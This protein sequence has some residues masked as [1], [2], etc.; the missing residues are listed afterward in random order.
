[1]SEIQ[2]INQKKIKRDSLEANSIIVLV[3][4]MCANVLGV[5]FQSLAGHLLG[6]T[7]LFADLNAV[8][9]LFN[10]LVLPTTVSSCLIAKYTAMLHVQRE[11]GKIK[12]FLIGMIKVL[13]I[14][15]LL[16]SGIMA[17]AHRSIGRWLHIEDSMVVVLAAVLAVI[18]LFS[19]VFTG[20]LQGS[21]AFVLYGVFG[22][23]GPVFKIVAIVGSL[24]FTRKIAGILAFWLFGTLFSYFVGIFLLKKVL[25]KYRR[26]KVS[27]DKREMGL[28]ILKL[29]VANAGVILI[30][31]IDVLMVKHNFNPEA[32]LYSGARTLGYSITYLTNT[33]IIVLFPMVAGSV[34][35]ERENLKLL[36]KVLVYDILLS[37]AAVLFL[38]LF[39]DICIR[40][41]LGNEYLMCRQYLIPIMAYVLP[42][43]IMNLLANYG[44]AKNS[45]AY[46]T[47][48]MFLSGALAAAGSLLWKGSL[49]ALIWC[50]A[51]VMWIV[52]L[53]NIIYIY[54]KG[55]KPKQSAD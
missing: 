32:G 48:S 23:I 36:K 44:M 46:S 26:E 43:G 12:S 7:Q 34:G 41:L 47:I 38:M 18:T 21:K 14:L 31:N 13:G 27:F 10:I 1:M 9:A 4:T 37:I 35:E 50:L 19:A 20:G 2:E 51:A 30:S 8:M 25:G 33:F 53:C 42:I 22:L 24:L 40:L 17:A 11:M 52:V 16:F 49:T 29:I 45:T 54:C 6:D 55:K 39:S 15:A 5:L 3:L 28:Y